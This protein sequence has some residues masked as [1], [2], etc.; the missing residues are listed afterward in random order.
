MKKGTTYKKVRVHFEP[1]N[2]GIIVERG[3]N[4]LQAAIDAGVHITASC[5]G[6]GVCGTCKV[7][8]EK[9]EV[10]SSRSE[11]LSQEEWEQGIRQAGQS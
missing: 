1:D 6:A 11:K 4:L 9:G 2:V 5:G 8:I 3:A 7:L 10:E